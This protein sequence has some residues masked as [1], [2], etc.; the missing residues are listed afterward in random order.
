[1]SIDPP[2]RP[3][4]VLVKS[5][6][7]SGVS[8][9]LSSVTL[10]NRFERLG[11][12]PPMAESRGD[13]ESL[14]PPSAGGRKALVWVVVAVAVVAT[15]AGAAVLLL[16]APPSGPATRF[17]ITASTPTPLPGAAGASARGPVGP[18]GRATPQ[19]DFRVE[20]T[21]PAGPDFRFHLDA[22]ASS[23]A[24][25]SV[26]VYN[27]T[28]GDSTSSQASAPQTNHVDPRSRE[29]ET[30]TI[31]LRVTADEGLSGSVSKGGR[32]TLP[33][34]PPNAA[35]TAPAPDA[36]TWYVDVDAS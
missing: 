4:H 33:P 34:L 25:G 12:G 2:S 6:V 10:G 5:Q 29:N 17:E 31:V 23:D 32:I 35:F 9:Y 20:R 14:Q 1:M 15:I 27:W 22:A 13:S 24:D 18:R 19:A 7:P 26:S 36:P 16:G 11:G 21:E 8:K 30:L 3:V 28:W